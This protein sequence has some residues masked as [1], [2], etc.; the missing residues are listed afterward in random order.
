MKFI[1]INRNLFDLFVQL[2]KTSFKMRYQNSI[3]G[4]L[5]VLIKPYS[6]F[7]VM[8]LVW[9]KIL[10]QNIPNYPIYLLLGIIFYTFVNELVIIG[11]MSLIDR[12]G[13]ILKV[14]FPRQI[15]VLSSLVSAL[16]NLGINLILVIILMLSSGIAVTLSG[17]L[18]CLFIAMII[19]IFCWGL[20]FFTSI[21]SIRF[22]DLKNILELGMFLLYWVTPILFTVSSGLI[23]STFTSVV[24]GNPL[25][26]LLNQVRAGFNI[27]DQVNIPLMLLYMFCAIVFAVLGG[28]FFQHNVKRIA[29]YF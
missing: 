7:L 14:N 10:N 21:I 6:T 28:V 19:F 16:I 26:I 25:G 17:I 27:Y 9:T 5:W 4:V 2:V 29:E 24:A 23:P 13:I 22:R 20:A 15:A 12:A 1:S 8:Y 11:Q 3:L 18:Y